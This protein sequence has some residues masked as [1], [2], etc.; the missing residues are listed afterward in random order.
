MTQRAI[1]YIDGASRGN[2]GPASAGVVIQDS[3]GET[4]KAFGLRLGTTTNNVAEWCAL[5]LAL[6]EGILLRLEAIDVRTDSELVARQISGQYKVKEPSLQPYFQLARHLQK[7]FREAS[8]R[9]VPR[10]QN[11]LADAEANKAL[12][13]IL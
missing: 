2:P 11:T 9:H 10:E 13:E 7:Q 3:D 1:A 12:D 4:I 6:Q 5:I 8:V